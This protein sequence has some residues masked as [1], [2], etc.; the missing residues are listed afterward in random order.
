MS[1]GFYAE[2]KLS[3]EQTYN[4]DLSFLKFS[5]TGVGTKQF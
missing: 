3:K 1:M 5:K 4:F 2:I